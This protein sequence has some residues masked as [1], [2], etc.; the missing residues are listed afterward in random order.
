MRPF[1]REGFGSPGNTARHKFRPFL[2]LDPHA[3]NSPGLMK[4]LLGCVDGGL[5]RLRSSE[6]IVTRREPGPAPRQTPASG[7][8][9]HKAG[10]ES[11]AAGWVWDCSSQFTHLV[12]GQPTRVTPGDLPS[13]LELSSSS[14]GSVCLMN[15]EDGSCWKQRGTPAPTCAASR[16]PASCKPCG[17]P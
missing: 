4:N 14:H 13:H 7:H 15:P 6:K 12:N 8:L 5:C 17:A 2:W 10:G 3:N 9:G 1:T 16:P 11:T